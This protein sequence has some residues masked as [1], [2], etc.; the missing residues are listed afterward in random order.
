M[1]HRS[2]YMGFGIKE[3]D[4]MN[5]ARKFFGT[6]GIRGTA[7]LYP[8][9][10][11]IAQKLGQ[12]AGLY[13]TK[14]HTRRHRVLVGKDTRLSGYMIESAL[15]AG[16]LSSGMEVTLVG[17]MPTPA[18]AMLTRSLR[19]DLGVMISASHNPFEDN[20]IKLF[21]PN[22]FKLSDHTEREIERL[23]ESDMSGHMAKPENIG[24]AVR[25]NDAAGRYV[26]NAKSSFPR[27]RRLDGLKIVID[28]ANGAAYKVAPTALWEL[29]AEVIRL[30]CTPDGT[31]INAGCGSTH[32]ELLCRTVV[33]EQADIGLAL[34]GDADRLLISDEK[35]RLIDGDQLLALIAQSWKKTDQL[36]TSDV[37]ATV[38]SNMGLERYL[39]AQ[40]MELV[41][42]AVGDRYVVE[43]MRELGANLGGEQS[44]HMVLS[45]FATTGD[46]LIAALQVLA[47]LVQQEKPASDVCKVFD[48]FPQ[49]LHNIRFRGSS[50]LAS[51]HVQK[52]AQSV[53]QKLGKRGRL[54]LRESGT[55]PLVRI[56]V[57][58]EDEKD[59]TDA[60]DILANAIQSVGVNPL[61]TVDHITEKAQKTEVQA[62][63][64][65]TRTIMAKTA[66]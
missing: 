34:D 9:T 27:G 39:N 59:V 50:P 58:A 2:W 14:E 48:P 12:A 15:V 5:V 23:M 29:G 10:V 55:E 21:G 17:P 8:M 53:H 33:E 20:G 31:N 43:K 61:S 7:N 40:G 24:R 62:T 52:A 45:D 38:M 6:D 54:V 35:G 44:G 64:K 22:G 42:T 11:E 26:E 30:G 63:K 1:I 3:T 49:R 19:A 56:M 46:G 65:T 51:D 41:R 28:C 57:E 47:V 25:L 60:I 18:I 37:V 36:S 32:P 13:F 66:L 4:I 16:F